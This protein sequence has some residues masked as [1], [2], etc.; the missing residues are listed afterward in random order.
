MSKHCQ[1]HGARQE[2]GKEKRMGEA[3]V[4]PEVA[5]MDAESKPDHIKVRNHGAGYPQH[6]DAFWRAWAVEA[7][8]YA[9]GCHRM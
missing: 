7:G 5:V 2:S 6:P 1:Y 4:A 9:E 8:A 3:A